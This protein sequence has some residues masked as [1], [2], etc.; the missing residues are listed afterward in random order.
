M[1]K[2]EREGGR[3]L[4]FCSCLGVAVLFWAAWGMAQSA[5]EQWLLS[6]NRYRSL[7]QSKELQW[8]DTLAESAAAYA[9]TCP[10]GHSSSEYGENIAWATYEQVPEKVVAR[11]Y[12]EEPDYDYERPRFLPESDILHRLCGG[13][14]PSS[15]APADPIAPAGTVM[16]VSVSITLRA[17]IETDLQKMFCLPATN[18]NTLW[19]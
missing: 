15:V 17:T 4:V 7:H 1:V 13:P 8:S 2:Q 3:R 5:S 18:R 11:W 9:D 6:H 16:S 12:G 19:P 14:P 10:R